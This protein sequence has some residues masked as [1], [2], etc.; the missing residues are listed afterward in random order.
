MSNL[1]LG[2]PNRIDSA[3]LSGGSWSSAFP[4]T[5]LQNRALGEPA[6]TSNDDTASTIIQIDQGS[7][8]SVRVIALV[9]HNMSQAATIRIKGDPTDLS[10]P[11]YDSTSISVWPV[12]YSA[13]VLALYPWTFVHILP[14]AA[15]HRLWKIEI[16]DTSNSDGY[17]QIAR[18]FIGPV[19]QPVVN[20]IY[21]ASLGW[22]SRALVNEATQGGEYFHTR[23]KPRVAAFTLDWMLQA[24]ALGTA[25][26]LMGA[27]DITE[28][29]FYIED[30]ADNTHA[31]RNN[32]LARLER[33][34]PLEYA[35]VALNSAAFRV[36]ELLP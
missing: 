22:Q 32:F 10:T 24:E 19:W 8:K 36:K 31:I 30:P 16:T 33:L 7:E 3:T 18:A 20:M 26:D 12:S 35:R 25:F 27:A 2:F 23:A 28:E 21:G 5:E 1:M 13:D 17:V 14:A 9:R 11:D 15:T 34:S 29:V 4:R 6:R